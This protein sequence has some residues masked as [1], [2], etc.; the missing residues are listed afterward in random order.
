MCFCFFLQDWETSCHLHL[1][2][3]V[4]LDCQLAVPSLMG[5]ALWPLLAPS[6]SM[7][8]PGL[9]GSSNIPQWRLLN[10]KPRRIAEFLQS[11]RC[12][13]QL[14]VPVSLADS[15]WN[16]LPIR[17]VWSSSYTSSQVWWCPVLTMIRS[18]SLS[19]SLTEFCRKVL[20][21]VMFTY[22]AR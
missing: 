12:D 4:T 2:P 8:P 22:W 3:W 6:D 20:Q 15:Q 10:C 19:T 7:R 17:T 13:H 5:P 14:K 11:T 16:N 1:L 21:L 9:H 18:S